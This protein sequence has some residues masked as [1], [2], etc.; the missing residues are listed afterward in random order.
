MHK[1]EDRDDLLE[2]MQL[3]LNYRWMVSDLEADEELDADV[4][5]EKIFSVERLIEATEKD[6]VR[7][8]EQEK[9]DPEI[10][11]FKGKY[12]SYPNVLPES[13]FGQVLQHYFNR[14]NRGGHHNT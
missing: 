4:K 8:M 7:F 2:G 14:E 6:I 5:K 10:V 1:I 3:V 12:H 11:V 13:D 9:L